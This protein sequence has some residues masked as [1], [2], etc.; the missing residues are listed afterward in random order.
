MKKE[1]F[2]ILGDI[3]TGKSETIRGLTGMRKRDKCKI[4]INNDVIGIYVFLRALPEAGLTPDD[5]VRELRE[6]KRL[7]IP[8]HISGSGIYPGAID[9]IKA[10]RNAGFRVEKM[11]ALGANRDAV[12]DIQKALPLP[13]IRQIE[14]FKGM[15]KNHAAYPIR[16][17]WGWR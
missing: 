1:L 12:K 16:K 15:P 10:F 3:H 13:K 6:H 7:L 4:E 14:T 9:Y 8:L 5:A 17:A 11:V 2:I